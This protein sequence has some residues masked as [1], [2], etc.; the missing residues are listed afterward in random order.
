MFFMLEWILDGTVVGMTCE[1][2]SA[3]TTFMSHGSST[4]VTWLLH[5]NT[6][7]LFD[8]AFHSHLMLAKG[9]ASSVKYTRVP[10]FHLNV[11]F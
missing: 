6:S 8:I 2:I 9:S 10:S 5:I 11:V 3:V 1:K 4:P 7:C